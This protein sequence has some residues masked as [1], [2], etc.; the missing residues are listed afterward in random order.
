[1]LGDTKIF[2]HDN[3]RAKYRC[4]RD[5]YHLISTKV[6]TPSRKQ[7]SNSAHQPLICSISVTKDYSLFSLSSSQLKSH[8]QLTCID[9]IF[10]AL[11]L[12]KIAY[13]LPAFTRLISVT[14]KSKINKFF[15]KA[16][17]RGLVT[18]I[19]TER[20]TCKARSCDRMSSVCLPV[21]L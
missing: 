10:Q 15:H 9:I 20:C 4:Y 19:F 21:C 16:H 17:R 2:F 1:M 12:S 3:Y 13:T 7:I 6:K 11:I 5:T 18:T 8:S 14:L